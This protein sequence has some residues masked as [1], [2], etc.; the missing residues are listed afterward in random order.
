MVQGIRLL[1]NYP[2]AW[3]DTYLDGKIVSQ[4]SKDFFQKLNNIPKEKFF[5]KKIIFKKKSQSALLYR[6]F[7]SKIA[8]AL[9]VS[10]G[11]PLLG[12]ERISYCYS[13]T[14]PF[15]CRHSFLRHEDCGILQYN[16]KQ[17]IQLL[18]KP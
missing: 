18:N 14:K 16:P 6:D 8:D 15:E 9:H 13:S 11:T 3:E 12:V 5:F 7:F 2:V 4:Y 10:K 1:Y 17:K